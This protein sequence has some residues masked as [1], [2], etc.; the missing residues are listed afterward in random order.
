MTPLKEAYQ[1]I[2]KHATTKRLRDLICKKKRHKNKLALHFFFDTIIF[3]TETSKMTISNKSFAKPNWCRRIMASATFA[4]SYFI[5]FFSMVSCLNLYMGFNLLE[6]T[7][8]NWSFIGSLITTMTLRVF[9]SGEHIYNSW[10]NLHYVFF[11]IIFVCMSIVWFI[12]GL[13]NELFYFLI[14]A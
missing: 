13:P 8:Y 7:L 3:L 2:F 12:P 6:S 14:R 11:V 5:I 10:Q 1:N 4:V 9:D